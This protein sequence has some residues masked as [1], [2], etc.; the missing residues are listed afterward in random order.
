LKE[1][2]QTHQKNFLLSPNIKTTSERQQVLFL[3]EEYFQ[4]RSILQLIAKILLAKNDR[5]SLSVKTFGAHKLI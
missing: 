1:E 2:T 4:E 5:G 3:I